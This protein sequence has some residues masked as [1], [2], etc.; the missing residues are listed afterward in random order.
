MHLKM[1]FVLYNKVPV[2]NIDTLRKMYFFHP[3]VHIIGLQ[4]CMITISGLLT[5]VIKINNLVITLV[6]FKFI[7]TKKFYKCSY[8]EPPVH[9]H[10]CPY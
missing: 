3:R 9:G 4:K 6:Y 1:S 10:A 8:K 5:I 2:P 7:K